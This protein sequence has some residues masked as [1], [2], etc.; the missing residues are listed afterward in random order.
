MSVGLY[1]VIQNN[2][3]PFILQVETC[4]LLVLNLFK[5]YVVVD[6]KIEGKA[7]VN[8]NK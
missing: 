5:N 4:N 2:E 1:N 8:I 7:I 6:F 3:E